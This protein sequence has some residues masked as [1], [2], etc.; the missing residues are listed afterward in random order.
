MSEDEA[1]KERMQA[2]G[3]RWK[4]FGYRRINTMLAREG[5]V[6][7]HTYGM[8]VGAAVG[9][10]V[11]SCFLSLLSLPWLPHTPFLSSDNVSSYFITFFI[12]VYCFFYCFIFDLNEYELP[13]RE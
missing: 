7:N 12:Y 4:R 9:V 10:A 3:A 11:P 8:A 1:I 2:L 6:I 13:V 5:T